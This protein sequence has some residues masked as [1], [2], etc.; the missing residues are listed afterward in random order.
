MWQSSRR[1]KRRGHGARLNVREKASVAVG[2][3]L[4]AGQD[5]LDG[6]QAGLSFLAEDSD[7]GLNPKEQRVVDASSL[8]VSHASAVAPMAHPKV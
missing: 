8:Q 6:L 7:D 4:T 1:A 3:K 5:T 2:L